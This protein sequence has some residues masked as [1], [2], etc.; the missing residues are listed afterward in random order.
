MQ[1]RLSAVELQ[2]SAAQ[3]ALTV[4]LSD[5]LDTYPN[6]TFQIVNL[7]GT[8]PF[9]FERMESIGRHRNPDDP[10]PTERLRQLWYDCASLGPRALEVAVKVLGADRIMLGSDFPIFKDDPY[11]HALAP[12]DITDDQ[13][14]QIAWKTADDLFLHLERLRQMAIP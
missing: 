7:G 1:Y 13:K 6:I 12:A 8:L 3:A 9:I 11:A 10:F 2:S 5:M 4:I 14:A